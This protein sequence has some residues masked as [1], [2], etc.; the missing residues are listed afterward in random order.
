MTS[1]QKRAVLEL[2]FAMILGGTI[3]VFVLE[4]KMP[5]H[6]II[7]FRCLFGGA[8]LAGL[9]LIQGYFRNFLLTRRFIGLA[10]LSGVTLVVN[11]LLLFKSFELASIAVTTILYHLQPFWIVILGAALFG[12]TFSFDKFL[13]ITLA[14]FGLGFAAGVTS[15]VLDNQLSYLIGIL[16]AIG[17]SITYALSTILT[18]S[19]KAIPPQVLA[20]IQTG[21]GLTLLWPFV[22]FDAL[23]DVSAVSWAWVLGLGFIHTGYMYILIYSAYSKLTTPV[24]AI[25][26]FIYP[27]VAILA[28]WVVYDLP[29]T[30]WQTLGFLMIA[31][32]SLGVNLGWPIFG[33]G[34]RAA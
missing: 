27:V 12:E 30:G 14:F 17:A 8:F 7:F 32:A 22:S 24:I 11:W 20:L 34:N 33:R 9:C 16:L 26:A 1:D 5:V 6:T 21:V 23:G 4:A 18:K 29:I 19:L 28:D 3:G 2:G 13:W 10:I 31:V 15:D 25:M